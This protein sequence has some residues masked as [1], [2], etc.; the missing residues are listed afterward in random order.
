MSNK[1]DWRGV[2]IFGAIFFLISLPLIGSY[3]PQKS[4][5]AGQ[6][7]NFQE[8]LQK[9]DS[10]W[11]FI[12]RAWDLK[13]NKQYEEAAAEYKLAI[14]TIQ[15]M[16][17]DEWPNLKK[18]DVDRM[19]QQTRIDAQIFPRYGLIEALDGAGRYEEAIQNVDWLMKNQQMKGKE[20]FLRAKL[21]GM[22][23]NLLQKIKSSQ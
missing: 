20:E 11:V 23:Q 19:N 21:E 6:A 8:D 15:N 16:P 14:K 18:E 10:Y 22:K 3:T 4:S 17:G 5:I 1:F 7:Q 12:N 2:A 13:K 9:A